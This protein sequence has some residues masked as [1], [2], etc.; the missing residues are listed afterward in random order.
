MLGFWSGRTVDAL[1][2]VK[3]H[4]EGAKN[5]VRTSVSVKLPAQRKTEMQ[6]SKP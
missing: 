3:Y 5:C 4:I 2:T 6:G 1:P